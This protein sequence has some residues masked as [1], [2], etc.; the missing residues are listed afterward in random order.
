MWK[1][2]TFFLK[3]APSLTVD[4][5]ITDWTVPLGDMLSYSFRYLEYV[6]ID[7]H[8]QLSRILDEPCVFKL[9]DPP[10]DACICKHL[11]LCLLFTF[12][13]Y[14]TKPS[15][16]RPPRCCIY[17]SSMRCAAHSV[18]YTSMN[19]RHRRV[20][21]SYVIRWFLEI[22]P[23]HLTQSVRNPWLSVNTSNHHHYHLY[24]QRQ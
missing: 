14:M 19:P 16:Y 2:K 7:F 15:I 20:L 18:I 8:S 6:H 9:L 21:S 4:T 5:L 22:F 3:C 11:T 10:G 1:K 12:F 24:L 17:V 23:F 13:F